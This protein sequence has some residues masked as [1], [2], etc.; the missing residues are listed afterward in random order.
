MPLIV[1]LLLVLVALLKARLK[2]LIVVAETPVLLLVKE[3]AAPLALLLAEEK[4]WERAPLESVKSPWVKVALPCVKVRFLP[5]AM[6]VSPFKAIA[7]VP[8]LKVPLPLMLKLP[9]DWE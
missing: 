6:V 3:K 9:E 5:A 2:P 8:V 7:P 1:L 4:V